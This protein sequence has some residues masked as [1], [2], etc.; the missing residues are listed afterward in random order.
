M[1]PRK[2]KAADPA[3]TDLEEAIAETAPQLDFSKVKPAELIAEFLLLKAHSEE[4]GKKYQEWIKP[5]TTRMETIRQLLHGKLLQDDVNG[6]PTDNGT[7]YLS[8][9]VTHTIDPE[10]EYTSQ[11][12]RVSRGR[13]ALLDWLLDNWDDYGSEGIQVG[14]SKDIVERWMNDHVNDEAWN[15]RPPPGLKLDSLK[16][17]N[18]K[19]S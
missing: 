1:P 12:G 18:I 11:E 3:Q 16:R 19:K 10:S 17:V 6:F 5:T 4:S 9:I 7:A 13:D 2:K 8:T 15:G 14:V